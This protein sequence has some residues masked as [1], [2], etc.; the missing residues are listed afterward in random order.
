ML[1][2][3]FMSTDQG[4]P[5]L[6]NAAGSLVSVLDACLVTGFNSL[7][8]TSLQVVSNVCTVTTGTSHG[9]QAGQRVTVAGASTSTLNGDKTVASAPTA[10]T[11]TFA[12]TQADVSETPG[13]GSVKRTPLGWVKEFSGTNKA[14]YKMSDPASYGQRL[15]VDDT[16][17]G[18]ASAFDARVIGVDNPTTVDAYADAFPTN[19]QKAGGGYWPKGANNAT[20]KFWCIVGDERFF[21]YIV[22]NSGYEGA[23]SI[24]NI[25]YTGGCFGDIISFKQ[26][27]AYGAI[28]G[29]CYGAANFVPACVM[30]QNT[31]LG[32]DP[33]T[34]NTRYI[35]RQHTGI[36]KSVP[37]GFLHPGGIS[38]SSSSAPS[39]PSPVD[40]GVVFIEPTLVSEQLATFGH[41]LRGILPGVVNVLCRY[42]NLRDVLYGDYMTATDG[43]GLKALVFKGVASSQNKDSALAFKVSAPW[44]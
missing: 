9:Y 26:G 25:G 23:Y 7:G 37:V 1:P 44:R 24:T 8:V 32:G 30:V 27:E 6:N 19:A 42:N 41:P 39:Y 10:T 36:T 40:N 35:S 20:G 13:S 33:G 22:E 11:F 18:V 17:T 14:V 2:I 31:N 34:T 29:A 3:V 12:V 38:S 15:R 5:V 16:A 28:L 43:S 4:A 21:Y